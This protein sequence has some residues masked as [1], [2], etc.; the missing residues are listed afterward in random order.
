MRKVLLYLAGVSLFAACSVPKYTYYFDYY[1]YNSGKKK[2]TAGELA[3]TVQDK[4]EHLDVTLPEN[5]L[6]IDEQTLTASAG[7]PVPV[8]IPE[9]VASTVKASEVKSFSEMSK[10]ERKEFKKELKKEIKKMIKEGKDGESVQATKQMDRDLKMAIIFG[11]VGLVLGLFGGIS[12]IF[13][14]LSV[15]A[16][17]VAVIFLIFWLSRQ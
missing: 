5:P 17:V 2:E 4:T 16:I 6:A 15:I 8:L 10:K 9:R 11:A 14:A 13:W 1:D 12:S 3:T 7:E